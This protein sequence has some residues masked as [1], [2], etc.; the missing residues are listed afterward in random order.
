MGGSGW[1][2]TTVEESKRKVELKK[3]KTAVTTPTRYTTVSEDIDTTGILLPI[4]RIAESPGSGVLA[5][6]AAPHSTV[7][8]NGAVAPIETASMLLPVHRVAESPGVVGG[9]AEMSVGRK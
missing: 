8:G 5:D 1:Y 4:H 7:S 2:T 9:E 3:L 6:S